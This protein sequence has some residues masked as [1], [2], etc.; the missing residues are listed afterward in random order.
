M[1]AAETREITDR[2]TLVDKV[3]LVFTRSALAMVENLDW[4]VGRLLQNLEQTGK[5]ENTIVVFFFA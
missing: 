5:I 1:K 2:A 4:N 3:D